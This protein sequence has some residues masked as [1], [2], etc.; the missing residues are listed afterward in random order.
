MK[1]TNAE[2]SQEPPSLLDAVRWLAKKRVF[3]FEPDR[4]WSFLCWTTE[5]VIEFVASLKPAPDTS[6][7][8]GALPK[9][10]RTEPPSLVIELELEAD[11]IT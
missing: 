6:G 5:E 8:I 2:A 4:N 9:I 7:F 11:E 3:L 1:R 10:T